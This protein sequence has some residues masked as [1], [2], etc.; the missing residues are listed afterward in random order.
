MH[1]RELPELPINITYGESHGNPRFLAEQSLPELQRVGAL[2]AGLA[3][4]AIAIGGWGLPREYGLVLWDAPAAYADAIIGDESS[5]AMAEDALGSVHLMY[6]L[7]MGGAGRNGVIRPWEPPIVG[8]RAAGERIYVLM[9][10]A[11]IDREAASGVHSDSYF[12]N[13]ETMLDALGDPQIVGTKVLLYDATRPPRTTGLSPAKLAMA[14]KQAVEL[15]ALRLADADGSATMALSDN[16]AEGQESSG[17]ET[18]R[19]VASPAKRTKSQSGQKRQEAQDAPERRRARRA[20][21][22]NPE[23]EEEARK[24]THYFTERG[25][26]EL[27]DIQRRYCRCTIHTAVRQLQSWLKAEAQESGSGDASQRPKNVYATCNASVKG[28]GGRNVCIP[29]INTASLADAELLALLHLKKNLPAR[30]AR[31][32]TTTAWATANWE[33]AV[34]NRQ[35]IVDAETR[36]ELTELLQEVAAAPASAKKVRRANSEE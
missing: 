35:R 29:Y 23:E 30:I 13:I 8:N 22:D 25:Q 26:R 9:V 3:E 4:S 34:A 12:A 10:T 31:F 19:K 27:S 5:D 2:P 15:R 7:S 18:K 32:L 24:N 28:A 11:P 20:S 1:R 14:A 17:N 16:E 36:R 6:A 21:R 33:A